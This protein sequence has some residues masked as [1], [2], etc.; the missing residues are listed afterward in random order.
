MEAVKMKVFARDITGDISSEGH[1]H[2]TAALTI[3]DVGIERDRLG[4]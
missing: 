4:E 2:R 1:I 3:I